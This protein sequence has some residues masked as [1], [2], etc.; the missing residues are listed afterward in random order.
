[1]PKPSIASPL[2]PA[3]PTKAGDRRFWGQLNNSNQALA[4]ASAAQKHQGLTLVITKD[5]LSAQRL[6]EEIAF[7]AEELPV[8]HLPDWEIL[9]YDTFSP[10]QDIISQRLFTFS[11]LPLIK[12][13]LLIVPIST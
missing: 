2:F 1:M 5:T 13:G 8:L 4:I 12:H 3:I 9:P 6:E 11:Q 10:H 7:F